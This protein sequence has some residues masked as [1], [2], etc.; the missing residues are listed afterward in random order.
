MQGPVLDGVRRDLFLK[1]AGGHQHFGVSH[2][3]FLK[4]VRGRLKVGLKR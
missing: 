3:H 2:T 4:V 1:H